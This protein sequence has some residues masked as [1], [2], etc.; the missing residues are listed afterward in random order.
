[1]TK[2]LPFGLLTIMLLACNTNIKKNDLTKMNL[3]WKI[4]SV[5]TTNY[6]AVEKF[7]EITKGSIRFFFFNNNLIMF[8]DRGNRIEESRYMADGTLHEKDTYKHEYDDKK[9]WIKQI[10]Y[11]R[12][13]KPISIIEREIVYY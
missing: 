7:D 4:H 2:I 5:K 11:N 9:N 1:M 6:N 13:N 10:K 8:N 12:E 3:K